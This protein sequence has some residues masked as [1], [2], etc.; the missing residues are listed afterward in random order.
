[1]VSFS[2]IGGNILTLYSLDIYLVISIGV[3]FFLSQQGY[4]VVGCTWPTHA[5]FYVI[6]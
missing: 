6:T 4:L 1:M 3:L 5:Y 2:I